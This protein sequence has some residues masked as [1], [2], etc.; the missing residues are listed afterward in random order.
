MPFKKR[1]ASLLVL[2]T[3]SFSL[4][5]AGLTAAAD[6]T[7]DGPAFD[8][9]IVRLKHAAPA[10]MAA[11]DADAIE[12]FTPIPYLEDSYL[13]Q[14]ADEVLDAVN[15]G[16]VARVEPNYIL[17]LLDMP[18][19]PTY[20]NQWALGAA[21]IGY[22]AL[23][24]SGLDGTGVTVAVIDSGLR[25][26]HE[27]LAGASI[28]PGSRNFLG[29][30]SEA[31]L[32][33]YT[34]DQTGHG[35]FVSGVIAAQRS[36]GTGIAG[37]ADGVNLL[38]LRCF[39]KTGSTSY[40]YDTAYDSGSGTVANVSSAIRY[41]VEQGAD[42]INMS[43]GGT[44]PELAASALADAV[45]DAADAGVI[46]TAA[47][48]NLG[49]TAYY[50]PASFDSVVSVGSYG[51][52]GNISPFSQHNDRVD[53]SAPGDNVLGID[54]S[55]DRSYKNGQG[56]SFSAPVAAALAAIVR[57][58]NN[59][60][61]SKAFHSLLPALCEDA[62]T[63]GRD[64]FFGYG[65]LK[66]ALML[67]A[68]SAPHAIVYHLNGGENPA[69]APV[70][71]PI[72]REE[73]VILPTPTKADSAFE[74]WYGNPSFTGGAVTQVPMDAVKQVEYWAK[75][76]DRPA[77]A[78]PVCILPTATPTGSGG[79]APASLDGQTA[80]LPFESEPISVSSL[81]DGTV[82][83]LTYENFTGMGPL[84]L[85]YSS[86]ANTVSFSCTPLIADAAR[87]APS[88]SLYA[89]NGVSKSAEGVHVL[90][91]A[92]VG[93]LPPSD[94]AL[95]ALSG[96]RMRG[97]GD[98]AIGVTLYGNGLD[99]LSLD[100]NPLRPGTG[101]TLGDSTID[102]QSVV[103]T[104]AVLDALDAG[105]HTLTFAFSRGRTEAARTG[106]YTLTVSTGYSVTFLK[107][108]AQH[109]KLENIAP[110]STVTLPA[111]PTKTN[112][113]FQG[114]YTGRT[115]TGTRF[116]AL[117][118]INADLIVYA[119]FTEDSGGGG[120]GGGG[121]APM[122]APPAAADTGV[123]AKSDV[124]AA[125]NA[126]GADEAPTFSAPRNTA[127]VTVE[128]GGLALL[129]AAGRGLAMQAADGSL[130][131][132]GAAL[133]GLNPSSDALTLSLART[134]PDSAL[135]AG[136]GA[137][138][139]AFDLA[140]EVAVWRGNTQV[141]AFAGALTLT[142]DVGAVNAGCA[143]R[144]L[145]LHKNAGGGYE[146][147]VHTAVADK[148]GLLP[149]T[150]DRL[151]V[152]LVEGISFKDVSK[153]DWFYDAVQSA[154]ASGLFSGVSRTRFAP[155]TPM[156]RAMLV[157]V[158]WRLSGRP[159]AAAAAS[160]TDTAADSY[161]AGALNWA[162]GQGIAAGYGDGRF[163]PDDPVTREQ[164]VSMLYKLETLTSLVP[165][166][167]SMLDRRFSDAGEISAWAAAAF[168]WA[169]DRGIITGVSDT[170]LAPKSTTTRA[171]A[172]AIL[173]R[174]RTPVD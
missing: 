118:A 9:Y 6:E 151:S 115:G 170:I 56:T 28:S 120:G 152:F 46:L 155:D 10:R 96:T 5:P 82:T 131:L 23:Y 11:L 157:A 122:S 30:G 162:V 80:V 165:Q 14:T 60:I 62:G 69:D 146:P 71:F 135:L 116:T 144:I 8:G 160:F 113:V 34:R 87:P 1:L 103:V 106:S 133:A 4:L 141:R 21:G 38:V 15:T 13:C 129:T 66:A 156:T 124:Q 63:S 76:T 127:S 22:E 139:A 91:P 107:D 153:S 43:F 102:G 17:E 55:G 88:F 150:L 72:G 36:S 148:N 58:Q 92:A 73:T 45:Q 52:D 172:A 99:L 105:A 164:M 3:L 125:L 108:G 86:G 89:W 39:S 67:G 95:T 42:V 147:I 123:Y 136:A 33:A 16:L 158:L 57:Q 109:K 49:G 25:S 94:S 97:T 65:K 110:G 50:W 121:G 154:V 85:T 126:A 84:T 173:V 93:P 143:M 35:T 68:L 145:Q 54:A 70:S 138:N 142:L 149:L 64:P 61:D 114:W 134:K 167:S 78:A 41:A 51:P 81:F 74:G 44:G 132:S 19:A 32:A 130:A 98:Y 31:V 117:T 59:Q 168:G 75:W 100:G 159:Q 7:P 166:G 119:H 169:V 140:F 27:A 2:L 137:Q 104:A 18:D 161:Y 29:D 79:F 111:D 20:G 171:Q 24:A 90:F 174:C 53:V 163:G 47:A 112:Y 77:P 12:G 48:G 128:G 101:Y 26:S 37:I 83:E 40:P